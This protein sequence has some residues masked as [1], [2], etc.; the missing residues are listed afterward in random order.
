[1]KRNEKASKNC[2]FSFVTVR[3]IVQYNFF[4]IVSFQLDEHNVIKG[5]DKRFKIN[6]MQVTINACTT[7]CSC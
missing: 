6:N 2:L 4:I 7:K 5:S 1:M 3:S